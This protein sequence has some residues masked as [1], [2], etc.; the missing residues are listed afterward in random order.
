MRIEHCTYVNMH[1]PYQ[2]PFVNTVFWLNIFYVPAKH[3]KQGFYNILLANNVGSLHFRPN[4]QWISDWSLPSNLLKSSINLL[5]SKI[6]QVAISSEP[7]IRKAFKI[8]YEVFAPT[9]IWKVLYSSRLHQ[10]HIVIAVANI[11]ILNK[12]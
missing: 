6:T 10:R 11:L 2:G 9:L 1:R 5:L 7:G 8:I 4:M 12:L 3:T